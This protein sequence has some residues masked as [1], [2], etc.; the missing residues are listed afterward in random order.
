MRV[1]KSTNQV[2]PVGSGSLIH[3]HDSDLTRKSTQR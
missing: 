3:F 2:I 1:L